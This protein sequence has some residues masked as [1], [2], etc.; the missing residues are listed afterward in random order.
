[1]QKKNSA[2]LS[3][4]VSKVVDSVCEQ[5]IHA[6]KIELLYGHILASTFANFLGAVLVYIS[7]NVV[8]YNP[9]LIVWFAGFG[10]VTLF[11][12]ISYFLYRKQ[13]I[14]PHFQ[15]PIFFLGTMALAFFW[16]FCVSY[17][18][19]FENILGQMIIVVVIAGVTAGSVQYLQSVFWVNVMYQITIITPLCARL[20]LQNEKT[21]YVIGFAM[22]IYF[23]FIMVTAWRGYSILDQSLR[24]GFENLDLTKNLTA[25]NKKSKIILGE[26]KQHEIEMRYINAMNEMLQPCR[27]GQEAYVIIAHTA[28]ALFPTISG[29]LYTFDFSTK[30]MDRVVQWGH[31]QILKENF[32]FDECLALREGRNY[33]IE[34][35]ELNVNCTHFEG[36]PSSGYICMPQITPA[37]LMGMLTLIAAPGDNISAHQGLAKRFNDTL[38]LALSNMHL[39]TTLNEQS[40]RDPLTSL[41]NRRYLDET[42]PRELKRIDRDE[43]TLCVCMINI[44]NFKDFNDKFG[45]DAGDEVLRQIGKILQQSVRGTDIVCRDGGDKFIMV[46]IDSDIQFAFPRLQKLAEKIKSTTL[47][48]RDLVLPSVTVSMGLAGAPA[49]GRTIEEIILAAEQAVY[50][51]KNHGRERVEIFGDYSDGSVES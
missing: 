39:L 40:I 35:P 26:L 16:G 1:M 47:A 17:L 24:L 37:G 45:H 41:Y 20:L 18:M 36:Q 46:L 34:K 19:P 7:L 48:R 3:Q 30:E 10:I 22:V 5:S 12:V 29:A 33:C 49:H 23:A 31:S 25:I 4:F 13:Y 50:Y 11:R 21:Y 14:T 2:N 32:P 51:A 27:G 38:K 9:V 44:D 15:L 43:T 6:H 42:L 8:D 28:K